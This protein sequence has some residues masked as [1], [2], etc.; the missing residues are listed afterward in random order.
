MTLFSK[1]W[2]AFLPL[3]LQIFVSLWLFTGTRYYSGSVLV[4]E[5]IWEIIREMK[6]QDLE[7]ILAEEIPEAVVVR[8]KK[9]TTRYATAAVE[10]VRFPLS[11]RMEGLFIAATASKLKTKDHQHQKNIETGVQEG[12][13]LKEEANQDLETTSNLKK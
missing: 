8:K 5:N 12:A 3:I 4:F 9:C 10:T 6:N 1:N 13:I 11:R 7:G 2:Y